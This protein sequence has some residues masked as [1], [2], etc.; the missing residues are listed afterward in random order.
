MYMVKIRLILLFTIAYSSI[1]SQESA[2]DTT[3][4][5][6]HTLNTESGILIS[7]KNRLPFWVKSSNSNRFTDESANS[8][9]QILDYQGSYKLV[10]NLSLKWELESIVTA[11]ENIRGKFVQ[12]NISVQN[13]FLRIAGGFDEEF[14][15][16]ND[17]TLSI[18]NLVYGNN[19]RPLPKISISTIGW[20]KSPLLGSALSFKAY[21]AHG[22]FEDNRFQKGA[23]LHQ[24]YFYLRG[25]AFNER[26]SLIFGLNHSAQWGGSNSLNESVQ[27]TG[28]KNYARIFLGSSGGEDALSTDQRNALGNHLGTYD[29]RGSYDFENFVLSNYWQFVWEDKSGLTPF[30]WRD[31]LMGTSVEFKKGGILQKFVFEIVRTNDQNAQK[32]S[33]DGVSFLEPD[34]FFNNGVYKTGWS[35]HD[36]VIGNPM[37]LILNNESIS[38]SRIKNS[39]NAVNIGISGQYHKLEYRINY[40]D[41]Q[42]KGTKRETIAPSIRLK[43]IDLNLQYSFNQKSS[44]GSRLNYQSANFETQRNFALQFFFKRSFQF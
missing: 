10:D 37:F 41:F 15:G 44:I 34:N 5:V 16:L 42:N 23:F 27:P 20:K 7:A 11:R 38:G 40:T 1:Y 29:I 32:I 14:F 4:T 35:Y 12:A 2:D 19:A 9:Y 6:L 13:N 22:K 33:K 30:N 8:I 25:N 39:I 21:L 17:S 18:G 26:L 24:K 36:S 43:S 28:L 3:Q 31:G